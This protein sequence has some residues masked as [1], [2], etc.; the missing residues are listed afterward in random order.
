MTWILKG[1]ISVASDVT[2]A[3]LISSPV[4]LTRA[5]LDAVLNALVPPLVEDY[6][7]DIVP[8]IVY[9]VMG[10]NPAIAAAAV[11]AVANALTT[12]MGASKC[13][14]LESGVW[15]WDGPSGPLA[16]HYL[17]PDDTGTLVARPTLFPRPSVSAPALEW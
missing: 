10:E 1:H 8:P 2:T 13:V 11:A 17:L 12:V 4:S 15:V 7:E 16:T 14:H 3:G 9:Q 6:A 5:A